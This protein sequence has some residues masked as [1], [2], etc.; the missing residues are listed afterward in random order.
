MK[1]AVTA[2]GS[3]LEGRL[4]PRFGRCACFLI[5]DT[6]DWSYV[7]MDNPNLSLGGGA[8]IQSAQM[9][10]DQGVKAV[11]TGNCGPNA[12][13]VLAAAG[14]E[15]VVGASGNV[16]DVVNDYL[17]GKLSS[18][19]GPNVE[20]HY[21]PTAGAGRGVGQGI[22]RVFNTGAG[23]GMGGGR[24]GGMGGGRGGGRGR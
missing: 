22:G 2:E 1:I 21:D 24:G 14:V 6:D 4:D 13:R 20:A 17:A 8:G 19:E 23:R 9:V 3:S 5:V 18:V 7:A 15:V 11:I 12:H 16:R 10:A